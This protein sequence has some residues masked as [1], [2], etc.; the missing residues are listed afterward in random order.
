MAVINFV[1]G[2]VGDTCED[3]IVINTNAAR[4][5]AAFDGPTLWL[6]GEN[7]S[8]YKSAHSRGNFQAF[9]KNGGNGKFLLYS[10]A[11][12]TDGHRLIDHP[13]IWAQDLAQFLKTLSSTPKL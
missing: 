4:Q 8:M 12:G 2:W 1:G 5:G 9:L 11:A 7:D 3:A 6:Y 10:L 13:D